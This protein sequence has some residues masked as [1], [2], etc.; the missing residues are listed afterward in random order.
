MSMGRL[1]NASLALPTY[2]L[3]VVLQVGDEELGTSPEPC[4]GLPGGPVPAPVANTVHSER[5]SSP[6]VPAALQ[7][8]SS[9]SVSA[10]HWTR[11]RHVTSRRRP[12]TKTWS[13]LTSPAALG[14]PPT[15]RLLPRQPGPGTG[16]A[17]V[18]SNAPAAP[19]RALCSS[20]SLRWLPTP[21]PAQAALPGQLCMSS[22]RPPGGHAQ[23]FTPV[24]EAAGSA[25][26]SI[27]SSA[28]WPAT[29]AQ[30]PSLAQRPSCP[31]SGGTD[32]GS[33][34]WTISAGRLGEL[35]VSCTQVCPQAG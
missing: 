10:S 9:S 27:G 33:S 24:P 11:P 35:Q 12:T 20:R 19:P 14:A 32:T 5:R 28:A 31:P 4:V 18:H 21:A 1:H 6:P 8:S 17:A 3:Q 23:C 30:A 22:A 7:S 29:H 15:Q 26:C 16:H 13:S 2:Y 25:C 34:Q